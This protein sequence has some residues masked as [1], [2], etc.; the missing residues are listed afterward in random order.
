MKKIKLE[1]PLYGLEDY[2]KEKTLKDLNNSYDI[3]EIV[4]SLD[5]E[6]HYNI[7]DNEENIF[8][9]L[10]NVK[11]MSRIKA[12]Q[13]LD[14][15]FEKIKAKYPNYDVIYLPTYDID[16]EYKSINLTKSKNDIE[17]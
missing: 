16:G 6:I 11:D 9:F 2:M 8:L 12:E 10:V 4:E 13:L 5:G 3:C 15:Y 14:N 1:I 7:L 17:L